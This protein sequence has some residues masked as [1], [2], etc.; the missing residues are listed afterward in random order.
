MSNWLRLIR[1][2]LNS[3]ELILKRKDAL[4]FIVCKFDELSEPDF[5]VSGPDAHHAETYLYF[6]CICKQTN[7]LINNV[8]K[9]FKKVLRILFPEISFFLF[10]RTVLRCF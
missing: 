1:L 3:I 9:S 5:F 2:K 8:I 10:L 4:K 7:K 6:K